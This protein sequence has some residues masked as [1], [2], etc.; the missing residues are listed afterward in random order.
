MDGMVSARH[1]MRTAAYRVAREARIVAAELD[2]Q[3][4]RPGWQ[5]PGWELPAERPG[6]PSAEYTRAALNVLDAAQ[7]LL[8]AAVDLDRAAGIGWPDVGQALGVSADTAA[9]R[10]RFGTAGT[11]RR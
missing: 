4:S 10:R 9:R 3:D 8:S 5:Q 2:A 1:E 7:Q 11:S 6:L